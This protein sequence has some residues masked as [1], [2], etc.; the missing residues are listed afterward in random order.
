MNS[1][2]DLEAIST[3][4]RRIVFLHILFVFLLNSSFSN[5][6]IA[7]NSKTF[8]IGSIESKSGEKVSGSLIIENGVDKGTFIPITIINGAKPGPVL[9]LVAGVHGTE[10]VPI[11]SLQQL[12]NEINPYELSGTVIMVHIA[13][14]PSFSDRA[15]Y[16]SPIDNKNLNL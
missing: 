4:N 7:Q 1:H 9:T 10:Y 2:K 13:N 16:S 15:V 8:T 3:S 11:I 6:L 5:I 14:I 12:S